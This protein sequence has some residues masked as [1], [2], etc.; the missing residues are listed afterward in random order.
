MTWA[1]PC[2]R[3]RGTLILGGKGAGANDM[4]LTVIH[5]DNHLLAVHK[6]AGLLVQGDRSGDP[7]LVEVAAAYLKRKYDKPGNVYVGLVHRL[8]RNVSGLV[9]LAR[10]SKAAGRLSAAFRE[11]QVTK[12][13][14][15]VTAGHPPA[16]EGNLRHWLAAAADHRGVTRAETASFP[17]A[18]ESELNYRV[19][20]DRNGMHLLVVQPLTKTR[21]P[22]G[23]TVICAD[24]TS[25]AGP[26]ELV[27]YEGGR[28]AA[29]ALRVP[30]VPV[31]HTII[32]IVDQVSLAD[33]AGGS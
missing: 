3:L 19:Q 24:S 29:M 5:E 14:L 28:E 10:T 4:D 8:D 11:G 16:E 7:T 30:F 13:Y 22:K 20:E 31:D 27:Y 2:Q 6:P 17:G 12:T 26:E 23:E 9:L 33:E 21:A 25:M 15:A 1:G 32:G 18:R